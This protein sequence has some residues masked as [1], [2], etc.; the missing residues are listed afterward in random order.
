M[1]THLK[2]GTLIRSA[3]SIQKKGKTT[4]KL[5]P[6]SSVVRRW[7]EK[8][9]WDQAQLREKMTLFWHGHFACKIQVNSSFRAYNNEMMRYHALGSFR[10]MVHEVARDPGML[11]FLNNQQNKKSHPNENFARE[12]MELFTIGIGHYSEQDIK[13]AARAFTGWTSTQQGKFEM[14]SKLHDYGSKT[15]MNQT[16][17]FDG[18]QIIKI[19]LE[20][21][22]TARFISRKAYKFFVN[23][24]IRKE[25]I[26]KIAS[27]FYKSDYDISV[28]LKEIFKSEW[29]YEDENIGTKIKSP[30]ELMVGIMRSFS[31]KIKKQSTITMIQNRLGQKLYMPPSVAGWPGG[32]NWINSASMIVRLSLP[33]KLFFR[34]PLD[35]E[36]DLKDLSRNPATDPNLND[37]MTSFEKLKSPELEQ[38]IS[39]YLLQTAVKHSPIRYKTYEEHSRKVRAITLELMASPEYQMY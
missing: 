29:F 33:S 28:M 32:L 39:K 16:G 27:A 25:R 21:E 10:D 37:Y 9:A 13:E 31:C 1:K 20:K 17:N 38:S 30:I 15:F 34:G 8:M 22:E 4:I 26:D 18:D 19:I 2:L 6:K 36:W 24:N 5:N 11:R 12:L 3:P 35:P 7:I 23:E 14:R